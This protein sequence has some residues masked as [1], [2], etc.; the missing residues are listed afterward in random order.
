[1]LGKEDAQ[2]LFIWRQASLLSCAHMGNA[3]EQLK[4]SLKILRSST[5]KIKT[6]YCLYKICQ[7][8]QVLDINV[9]RAS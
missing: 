9:G 6:R 8:K 4:P 3:P 7:D 5:E 1:M 2:R